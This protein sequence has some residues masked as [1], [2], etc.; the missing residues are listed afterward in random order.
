MPV[1]ALTRPRPAAPPAAA[2]LLAISTL[3]SL[4]ATSRH[5]GLVFPA[6]DCLMQLR[7]YPQSRGLVST[8]LNSIRGGLSE[9]YKATHEIC[10]RVA[11]LKARQGGRRWLCGGAE[12]PGPAPGTENVAEALQGPASSSSRCCAACRQP[13]LDCAASPLLAPPFC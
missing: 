10:K 11:T 12:L 7:G 9:V 8:E 13:C 5:G 1:G 2:P 3:P 6:K 4:A